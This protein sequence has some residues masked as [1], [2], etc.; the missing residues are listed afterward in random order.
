MKT[1][2]L[3]T[4]LLF[5][6]VKSQQIKFISDTGNNMSTGHQGRAKSTLTGVLLYI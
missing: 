2:L 1:M 5:D 4:V 3:C 6:I